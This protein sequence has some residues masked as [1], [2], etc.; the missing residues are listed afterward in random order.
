MT[1]RNSPIVRTRRNPVDGDF[2]L[3]SWTFMT[4]VELVH[5]NCYRE[6]YCIGG[7]CVYGDT[8]QPQQSPDTHFTCFRTAAANRNC[9][10]FLLCH[11]Q[12]P[13]CWPQQPRAAF[14]WGFSSF[15]AST[16]KTYTLCGSNSVLRR[17]LTRIP[18]D[19]GFTIRFRRV[20][21]QRA[22]L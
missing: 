21:R 17:N 19:D 1:R 12:R 18:H 8:M 10:G 15:L 7:V 6:V 22:T 14:H 13:S 20:K 5:I 3:S 2:T 16:T 4:G 11:S 9:V